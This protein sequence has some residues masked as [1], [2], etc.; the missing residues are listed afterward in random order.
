MGGAASPGTASQ[1]GLSLLSL[2]CESSELF[3]GE[4][5][6]NC[7]WTGYSETGFDLK[8]GHGIV[9][10]GRDGPA[11]KIWVWVNDFIIHGPT[12]EKAM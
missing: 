9:L 6:A 7:W 1:F 12:H 4:A 3:Q 10:H 8:L 2:L 5:R 11:V